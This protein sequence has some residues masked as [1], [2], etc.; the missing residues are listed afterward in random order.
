[1]KEI[2]FKSMIIGVL[3]T[4]LIFTCMG[5]KENLGDITVNSIKV[6]NDGVGGFI[7][8]MNLDGK[9]VAYLGVRNNQ[10]GGV[11]NTYNGSGVETSF[12][13]TVDD[14]EYGAMIINNSEGFTSITLG[15]DSTGNGFIETYDSDLNMNIY[16]GAGE[17]GDGYLKTYNAEWKKTLLHS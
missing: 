4:L 13:G 17:D 6:L 10:E 15:T 3:G 12:I 8:I 16:L 11:L 1:M 5:A 14:N 2:D 7:E 9:R